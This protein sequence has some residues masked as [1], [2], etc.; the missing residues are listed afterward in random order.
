MHPP[1]YD[2]SAYDFWLKPYGLL[3]ARTDYEGEESDSDVTGEL[4]V[5]LKWRIT[6][7]FDARL[8]RK[9]RN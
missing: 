5:D 2:F 6:P 8:L 9:A 3:S 4:G 7:S 1:I